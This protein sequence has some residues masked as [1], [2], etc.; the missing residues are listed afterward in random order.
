MKAYQAQ[1]LL[2]DHAAARLWAEQWARQGYAAA[3]IQLKLSDKGFPDGLV[4][5][6]ITRYYPPTDDE[7]RAREL[8]AQRTRAGPHRATRSRLART[9][10][11][12]GFDADLIE[13]LLGESLD[14]PT[15]SA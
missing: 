11:S 10:A 13:R 5:N 12:R 3:A 1:G 14:D 7:A 4:T 6:V 8:L 2:D 15:L 9:L